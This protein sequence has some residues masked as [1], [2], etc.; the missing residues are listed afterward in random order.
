LLIYLYCPEQREERLI[1]GLYTPIQLRDRGTLWVA[2]Y[3]LRDLGPQK[4]I[5]KCESSFFPQ[6]FFLFGEKNKPRAQ[7]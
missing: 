5:I 1:E 7:H 6:F 2:G 4:F 3:Q